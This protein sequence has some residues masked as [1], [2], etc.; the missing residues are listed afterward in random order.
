M[1]KILI[2]DQ[3]NSKDNKNVKNECGFRRKTIFVLVFYIIVNILSI[4]KILAKVAKISER[5][6]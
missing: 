6:L 2:F 5:F 4:T 1:K 3:F